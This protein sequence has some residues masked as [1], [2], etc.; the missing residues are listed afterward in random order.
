MPGKITHSEKHLNFDSI[1]SLYVNMALLSAGLFQTT[2][3]L[4][5][6]VK[7]P[8]IMIQKGF[9]SSSEIFEL[10]AKGCEHTGWG[11]SRLVV[12][13]MENNTKL[14]NNNAGINSVFHIRTTVNLLLPHSGFCK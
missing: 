5:K 9:L 8:I 3:C 1:L 14:I 2:P 12:V 13:C 11:K 4:S 7:G 10:R 6:P